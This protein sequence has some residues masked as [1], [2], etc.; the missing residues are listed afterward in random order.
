MESQSAAH[1]AQD[2]QTFAQLG[3]ALWVAPE[4]ARP[5][6]I[7]TL[8]AVSLLDLSGERAM[9]R[10][11]AILLKRAESRG[12]V[13]ATR[14][15]LSTGQFGNPFFK[16]SALERFVLVTL[17]SG[18]WSYARMARVT[19]LSAEDVESLAWRSRVR[20]GAE[21]GVLSAGPKSLGVACP[22][23]DFERPWTQRFLDEE[24]PSSRDRLFLQNHVMACDVC[25]HAL[26]RC[27]DLYFHTEKMIPTLP[28]GAQSTLVRELAF[29]QRQGMVLRRNGGV[30]TVQ[31]AAVAFLRQT[32]TQI[33][34][35]LGAA[36][37]LY[38]HFR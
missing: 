2:L 5:V 4:R 31:A 33:L 15:S 37:V 23:Y 14:I 18:R 32:D 21:S 22:E 34:L 9:D 27:R 13:E 16:L 20:L 17:H 1:Q 38:L 6:V 30:V 26:N 35:A 24:M 36:L 8:S 3:T 28:N 12:A 10:A 19:G 29:I 11:T 25:R 7:E